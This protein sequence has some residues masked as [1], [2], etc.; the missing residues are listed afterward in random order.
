VLAVDREDELV[1]GHY[2]PLHP[3]V[4]RLIHQVAEAAR[5]ANRP[6]TICGEMAGNPVHAALLIGLGVR[7]FSV[8]PGQMLEVKQAIRRVHLDEAERLARRALELATAAEVEALL[9]AR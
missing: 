1:A 5:A 3:S 8:A 9:T 2:Q 4:L 6:L 7:R